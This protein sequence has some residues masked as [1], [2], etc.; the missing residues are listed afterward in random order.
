M[1]IIARQG[2]TTLAGMADGLVAGTK[3]ATTIGWR[4]V[5]AVS[6]G[7]KVLTFDAGMQEVTGLARGLLWAAAEP[8]P[9]HLWPLAVPVGALGNAQAMTLLPEQSVMVE[10]DVGEE[11]YGDPF[12]L[13][14]AA[15]LDGLR[16]IV[17]VA[18]DAP[19]AVTVLRFARDQ[20]VFGS[21]GALLFCPS[22]AGATL[23]EL[24]QPRGSDYVVL[25][26]DDAAFL[27]G[28]IRVDDVPAAAA[29]AA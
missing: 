25:P 13:I 7:D 1:T 12:T 17:R 22:R 5:E 10:S 29:R 9:R 24:R 28:C 4:A 11:I 3:V 14:P 26:M 16:G 19:V 27:I 18:P 8:C 23:S 20:V 15:A 6:V 21:A 2:Q